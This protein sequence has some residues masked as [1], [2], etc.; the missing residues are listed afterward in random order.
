[1]ILHS[2]VFT[3]KVIRFL[4]KSLG[5]LW[6]ATQTTEAKAMI[7]STIQPYMSDGKN[8]NSKSQ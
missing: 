1:M 3:R 4:T 7:G 2:D 6:V 8:C 5:K